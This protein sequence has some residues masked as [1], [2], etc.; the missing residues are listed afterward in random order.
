MQYYAS[1]TAINI[2]FIPVGVAS[3]NFKAVLQLF[4]NMEPQISKEDCIIGLQEVLPVELLFR[5]EIVKDPTTLFRLLRDYLFQK[6]FSYRQKQDTNKLMIGI[7]IFFL[8]TSRIVNILNKNYILY[9]QIVQ[10]RNHEF[11][12]HL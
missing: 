7:K 2:W 8:K 9:E 11:R 10:V 12:M 5:D 6:R 1:I 3:N 4:V